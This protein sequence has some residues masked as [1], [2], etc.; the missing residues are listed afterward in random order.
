MC[1]FNFELLKWIILDKLESE[2]QFEKTEKI[3]LETYT[4]IVTKKNDWYILY[5]WIKIIS[6]L[7]IYKPKITKENFLKV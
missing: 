1:C 2:N 4:K 3:I 7:M 5:S 6:E